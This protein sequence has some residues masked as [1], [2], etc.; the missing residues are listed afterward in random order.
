MATSKRAQP[1]AVTD[2]DRRQAVTSARAAARAGLPATVCP[3]DPNGTADQAALA[4][5]WV[6]EYLAARPATDAPDDTVSY[7]G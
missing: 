5:I 4:S 3:F 6:R 7:D 1:I 2:D